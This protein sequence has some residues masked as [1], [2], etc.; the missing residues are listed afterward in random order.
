MLERA[1]STGFDTALLIYEDHGNPSQM[2]FL[3]QSEWL[4]CIL[5]KSLSHEE[6]A[7]Q[8]IRIV[9][10]SLKVNGETGKKI[11]RLI[12]RAI[13]GDEDMEASKG[14]LVIH[15]TDRKIYFTL[16][17]TAMGPVIEIAGIDEPASPMN[18]GKKA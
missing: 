9:S 13:A 2:C 7:G 17:K 11:A 16:D 18:N 6:R 8:R 5:I 10:R 12:E 1:R 3:T 15:C 14:N 4:P